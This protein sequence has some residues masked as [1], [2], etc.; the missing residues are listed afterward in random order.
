M[1]TGY[2]EPVPTNLIEK[3]EAIQE[4]INTSE[5]VTNELNPVNVELK[6]DLNANISEIHLT[7]TEEKPTIMVK[8]RN[9]ELCD[10]EVSVVAGY[11]RADVIERK[12][13][14]EKAKTLF[15][16]YEDIFYSNTG[17]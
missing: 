10:N 9:T 8:L 14:D 13:D 12:I 16:F 6:M 3:V 5:D 4:K 7:L 17:Q 11:W 15:K 1:E 2:L